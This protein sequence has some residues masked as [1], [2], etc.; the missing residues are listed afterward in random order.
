MSSAKPYAG[1]VTTDPSKEE[2]ATLKAVRWTLG[3]VA[4]QAVVGIATL[5]YLVLSNCS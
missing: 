3:I 5:S 2:I 1:H 4:V